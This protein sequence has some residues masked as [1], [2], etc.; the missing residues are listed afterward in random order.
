MDRK[1]A[2]VLKV[3][4][5]VTVFVQIELFGRV[6]GDFENSWTMYM[7]QPCCSGTG[8]HHVRHHRGMSVLTQ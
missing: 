4:F 2:H 3:W 6:N 8:S 7:E 1:R 5:V